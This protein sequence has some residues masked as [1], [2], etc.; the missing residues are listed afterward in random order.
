MRCRRKFVPEIENLYLTVKEINMP[1]SKSSGDSQGSKR[2]FA[3]MDEKKQRE[4]ASKGGKASHGG[5]GSSGGGSSGQHTKA[6]G[7]SHKNG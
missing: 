3:S 5:K 1:S 2:G 6:G 7:Q 4:S